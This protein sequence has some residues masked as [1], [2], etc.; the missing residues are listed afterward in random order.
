VAVARTPCEA[1]V[2]A[3]E[4]SGDEAFVIGGS[5]VYR[6]FAPLC[7]EAHLTVVDHRA[8]EDFDGS[9]SWFPSKCV[10][11]F[12]TRTWDEAASRRLS[13]HAVYYHLARRIN[14]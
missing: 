8:I 12:R 3:F 7:D 2:S 6:L 1:V 5:E 13:R 10:D 9:A 11:D 4:S 14:A